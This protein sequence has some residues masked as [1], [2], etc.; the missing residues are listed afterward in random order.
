MNRVKMR[1]CVNGVCVEGKWV[2]CVND[3]AQRENVRVCVQVC[4]VEV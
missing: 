4:V 1:A 2:H 3:H